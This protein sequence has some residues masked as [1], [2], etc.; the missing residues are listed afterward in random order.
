MGN[1]NL[2]SDFASYVLI[3]LFKDAMAKF[4]K[5]KKVSIVSM[6]YDAVE[7]LTIVN[8]DGVEWKLEVNAKVLIPQKLKDKIVKD[9]EAK[10]FCVECTRGIAEEKSLCP[11]CEY[12]EKI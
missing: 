10:C 12:L 1:I 2:G 6:N 8:K 7:G 9:K 5:S 11:V 4:G 3:H